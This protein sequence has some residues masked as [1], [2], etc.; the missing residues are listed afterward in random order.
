MCYFI[1]YFASS[2]PANLGASKNALD[3]VK[4][5]PSFY[6]KRSTARLWGKS[7]TH[8]ISMVWILV[9]CIVTLD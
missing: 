9:K 6:I 1:A 2:E 7:L 3:Y 8:C 5:N 4:D